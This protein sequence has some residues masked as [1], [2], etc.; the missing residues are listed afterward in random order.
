MSEK[1]EFGVNSRFLELPND[2]LREIV[3]V[4]DAPSA[5]ALAL[6][7]RSFCE[8]LPALGVDFLRGN[9][10]LFKIC[11]S[12]HLNQFKWLREIAPSSTVLWSHGYKAARSGNLDLL[13]AVKEVSLL[14]SVYTQFLIYT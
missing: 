9:K 13:L 11:E 3:R 5:L 2:M 12:G 14:N 8:N 4:S 6:S 10:F 1:D 7:C